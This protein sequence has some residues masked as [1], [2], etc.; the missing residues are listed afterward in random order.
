M[1]TIEFKRLTEVDTSDITLLMNHKLV[2][3]QMPLLTN[4][5]FNEKTCEKFIDI[6]ESLWIKHGYGPWAFVIDCRF[7]GWGGLQSENGE[8]DLAMVLHP[9]FWGIGKTLY[10]EIIRRAF[11][12]MKLS[13]VTVLLPPTRT[14]ISGL[15]HLGF[16]K[17][18]EL[19]IEKQHFIKYRLEKTGKSTKK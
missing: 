12:E 19:E 11:Y 8:A 3:K 6:K 16:K 10:K 7:A 15:L 17:D 18:S 14:R 2:R 13:S 1:K 4:I 9:D 5:I